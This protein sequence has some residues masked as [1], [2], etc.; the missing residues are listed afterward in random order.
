MGQSNVW[1]REGNWSNAEYFQDFQEEQDYEMEVPA[2][3]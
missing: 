2:S 3:E 1:P